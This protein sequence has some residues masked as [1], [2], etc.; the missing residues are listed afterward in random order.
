MLLKCLHHRYLGS[1]M[2]NFFVLGLLATT[3]WLL[4]LN[5]AAQEE[6]SSKILKVGVTQIPRSLHP[7]EINDYKGKFVLN[8]YQRPLIYTDEE[9]ATRCSLCIKIPSFE[10]KQLDRRKKKRRHHLVANWRIRKDARWADKRPVTVKDVLF[11]WEIINA[12]RAEGSNTLD[13]FSAIESIVEHGNPREFQISYY[14]ITSDFDQLDDFFLLP[15]HIEQPIWEASKKNLS[16]YFKNSLYKKDPLNKGLY[17]GPFIVTRF[18]YEKSLQ[19]KQNLQFHQSSKTASI[20]IWQLGG[21]P[22][23]KWAYRNRSI[24]I[25]PEHELSLP[26]TVAMQKDLKKKN[27]SANINMVDTH[28]MNQIMFNLRNPLLANRL[29]R[30]AIAHAINRKEIINSVFHGSVKAANQPFETTNTTNDPI[31]YSPGKSQQILERLGWRLQGKSIYRMKEQ[32]KL[33]ITIDIPDDNSGRA[34]MARE[35]ANQL[36]QVGIEAIIKTHPVKRYFSKFIPRAE[37]T[38]LAIFSWPATPTRLP[39]SIFHSAEIP[40]YQNDYTGQNIG[41]WRDSNID[42]LLSK[43]SKELDGKKRSNLADQVLNIWHKQVPFIPLY[44]GVKSSVASKDVAGLKLYKS[45]TP[46]SINSENWVYK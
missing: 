19:L 46:S 34:E 36:K 31:S 29:L 5:A 45:D 33:S 6:H 7:Y 44:Y 13:Q 11:T 37:F 39:Y 40:T 24:A 21:T 41:A 38:D 15:A 8:F 35:L 2:R 9:G 17:N 10:N 14:Q 43:F 16:N 18:K 42:K 20:F 27:I 4:A 32:K 25:I 3:L 26:E 28:R 12:I 1:F 22:E 30:V 23:L